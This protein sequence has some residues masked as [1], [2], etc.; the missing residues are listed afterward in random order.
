ML[1][2]RSLRTSWVSILNKKK[3]FVYSDVFKL[4]GLVI[5]SGCVARIAV[6]M[7]ENVSGVI[8]VES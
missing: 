8:L 3:L 2:V 6:M 4:N 1:T 5:T 7:H